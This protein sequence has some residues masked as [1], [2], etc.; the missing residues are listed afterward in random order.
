MD[1]PSDGG[2]LVSI[3]GG[4]QPL[5]LDFWAPSCVPCATKVPELVAR[6]P[7]LRA[8]GARLVLVGVLADGET[9]EMARET[10]ASWGVER[11]FLIDR[12]DVSRRA[13]GVTDL[14]ATLVL[15]G[16]HVA[17]WAGSPTSPANDVVAATRAA[18]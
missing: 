9:T 10:L 12:E 16:Q 8:S 11:P 3:G 6:E 5:V 15:N 18:R 13:A 1:L 4:G 2:S 17:T 7:D 14:P